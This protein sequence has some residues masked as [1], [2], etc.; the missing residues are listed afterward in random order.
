MTTS[1]PVSTEQISA[2]E[3]YRRSK[4]YARLT[5][6][7][8]ILTFLSVCAIAVV[9]T[10]MNERNKEGFKAIRLSKPISYFDYT[11]VDQGKQ[12]Q[13]HQQP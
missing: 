2:A 7:A 6:G 3:K 8:I 12:P 5:Y 4:L 11:Y 1:Q 10:M 13:K 9:T